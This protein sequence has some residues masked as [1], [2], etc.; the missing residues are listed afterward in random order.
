M[1]QRSF[2]CFR[3]VVDWKLDPEKFPKRIDLE[4]SEEV[5][6]RLQQ[7]SLRTGLSITEIASTLVSQGADKSFRSDGDSLES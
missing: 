1:Q 6:Y 3:L 5:L 7:I 4:V 2:A